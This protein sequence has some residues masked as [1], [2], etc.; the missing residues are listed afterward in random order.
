M[1]NIIRREARDYMSL[2]DAM[3]RLFDESFLRPFGAQGGMG[4]LS[5]PAVDLIETDDEVVVTATVPG[6]KPEDLKITLVG[7]VLQISGQS[8][9]QTERKD[10]TYHMQERRYGAFSRSIPL[11]TPVV[12]DKVNAEFENGELTVRL[13]KA[14]E[15]RPKSIAI[16]PNVKPKK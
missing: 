14:Q 4:V 13:P 5:T 15:A 11:P 7:D 9:A 16:K 8:S 2:R 1:A 6:L 3:D 10:A 12:S